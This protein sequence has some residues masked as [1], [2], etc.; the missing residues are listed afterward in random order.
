MNLVIKEE[1]KK[2]DCENSESNKCRARGK[3]DEINNIKRPTHMPTCL[4]TIY[5]HTVQATI[6]L[7]HFT[8]HQLT[9]CRP[10]SW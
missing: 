8:S 4:P 1:K 5:V 10:R 3:W 2:K 7:L 6:N 9:V